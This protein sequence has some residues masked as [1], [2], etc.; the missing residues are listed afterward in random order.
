MRFLYN[1]HFLGSGIFCTSKEGTVIAKRIIDFYAG[2][3]GTS[4]GTNE[5][6]VSASRGGVI[7]FSEIIREAD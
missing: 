2:G 3:L 7:G 5:Q 4:R 1:H 6:N